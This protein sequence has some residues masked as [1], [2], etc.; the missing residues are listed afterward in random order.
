MSFPLPGPLGRFEGTGIEGWKDV[1]TSQGKPTA[2]RS[3]KRGGAHFLQELPEGA[4]LCPHSEF[5]PAR[6]RADFWP[7]EL[8]ENTFL[9]F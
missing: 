5:S 8:E 6:L 3:W 9:L 4:Q 7:P 2:T 1:P